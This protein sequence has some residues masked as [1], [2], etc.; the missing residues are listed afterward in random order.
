MI[1]PVVGPHRGYVEDPADKRGTGDVDRHLG[2]KKVKEGER[3]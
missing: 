1:I 2:R 3:R